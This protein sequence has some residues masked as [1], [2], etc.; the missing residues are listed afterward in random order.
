M[1][2]V[3]LSYKSILNLQRNNA[4]AV[5]NIGTADHDH[6]QLIIKDLGLYHGSNL[7]FLSFLLSFLLLLLLFYFYLICPSKNSYCHFFF[8]GIIFELLE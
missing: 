7:P 4:F 8:A 1:A 2:T 3:P 5:K 6:L